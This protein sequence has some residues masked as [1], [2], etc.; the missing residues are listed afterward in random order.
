M[1]GHVFISYSRRQGGGYVEALAAYLDKAGIP[2]WFDRDIYTGDRWDEVIRTKV[3]S[4]A[5]LIVVMTPSADS[6]EWVS[7][8]L[9]RA[10]SQ[11][12]RVFPL[13]LQ[14][15]PF[16]RLGDIQ[17]EDVTDERMPSEH[18]V[19]TLRRLVDAPSGP[20]PDAP[21]P[22]RQ[23][24]A[25]P[26]PTAPAV[27]PPTD[28][29][30]PIPAADDEPTR[31]RWRSILVAIAAV[32]VLAAAVLGLWHRARPAEATGPSAS[33]GDRSSGQSG[34]PSPTPTVPGTSEPGSPSATGPGV[35]PIVPPTTTTTITS[36]TTQPP[37]IPLGMTQRID[38][39]TLTNSGGEPGLQAEITV[40]SSLPT[41][42]GISAGF[43]T[44]EGTR[45][46]NEYPTGPGTFHYTYSVLLRDLGTYCGIPG[47]TPMYS[48]GVSTGQAG[49]SPD[50]GY[51]PIGTI[52]RSL[53]APAPCPSPS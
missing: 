11:Q 34:S 48:F 45:G 41:R 53:T 50:P 44:P 15:E 31:S 33:S 32:A 20:M 14:G 29:D 3:D 9:T 38:S 30:E 47:S 51:P 49:P 22:V 7:R 5:A 37:T 17:Y 12:K 21:V 23:A 26:A 16:F 27:R 13:L 24:D 4:C 19:N 10:A 25:V 43:T 18:L 6:S 42:L 36:T 28:P 46:Y 2:V 1:G 8:E 35:A 40:T 39:F 52:S